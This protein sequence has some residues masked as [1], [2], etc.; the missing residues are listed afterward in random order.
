MSEP[1]TSIRGMIFVDFWN[2]DLAMRRLDPTFATDWIK[3]PQIIIQEMTKL[4]NQPVRYDRCF[5]F[6][7]YNKNSAKDN[8]LYSWATNKLGAMPGIEVRFFPRQERKTGP[9]CTGAAH[10]EIKICPACGASM[11]GTQEKGVDTKIVIEMFDKVYSGQCDI[12]T[13][14]SADKDFAPAVDA[15]MGKGIK[16][17]HGRIAHFGSNLTNHC[18]GNINLFAIRDQFRR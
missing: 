18:W 6:G 1:E 7:S 9:C 10:H 15:I 2:Y 16:I 4:V 14:V 11:L 13:I 5:V 12:C 17:I 3:L 8:K